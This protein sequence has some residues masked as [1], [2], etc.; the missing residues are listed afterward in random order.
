MS[1]FKSVRWMGMAALAMVASLAA[2]NDDP[3]VD[4][5]PNI[6]TM[7]IT[8]GSQTVDVDV[9]GTVTGGPITLTTT[10]DPAVTVQWLILDGSPDPL[11]TAAEFELRV[12]PANTGIVTFTSTGAFTGT[13]NGVTTGSTTIEFILW[14]LE[15]DHDEFGE[16]VPVPVTVS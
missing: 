11:V 13:L 5:E 9:F 2:C 4:D 8:I 10:V 7:R 6:A 15:E 14:H 3:V 16:G 1:D 12:E